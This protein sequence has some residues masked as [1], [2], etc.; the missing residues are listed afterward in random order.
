MALK[1]HNHCKYW[2]IRT[3]IFADCNG[4][5]QVGFHTEATQ[6]NTDDA[7]RGTCITYTQLPCGATCGNP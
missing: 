1:D 2:V 3:K 5:F 4:P 7:N 6:D